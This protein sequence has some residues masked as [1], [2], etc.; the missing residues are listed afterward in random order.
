MT[1]F[2]GFASAHGTY[3]KEETKRGTAKREIK[4]SAKTLREAVTLDLWQRHLSGE[5]P[6]GIITIRE[7]ST[8][9][10]GAIDI[11]QYDMDLGGLVTQ[12]RKTCKNAVLCR[13]KS[14][15]AHVFLFM[16]EPVPAGDMMAKLRS[17]SSVI[18]HGGSEV[19]PKQDT[20]LIDRGDLGNWLNM[21]YFGGDETERYAIKEDGR[22]LSMSQFLDLAE[23]MRMTPE[24]LESTTFHATVAELKDG[25]PC[26][27]QLGAVKVGEGARNNGLFAY[28]VLAKKMSPDGW[29]KVL[30]EW[31]QKYISP[32]L[33]VGE[34]TAVVRSLRK[35]DYQYKCKDQPIQSYCNMALCRHRKYG[36]G[37][38]GVANIVES[39]TILDTEPPLFFVN[40]KTGGTVECDSATLL[41]PRLFQHEVLAQLKQVCFLYKLDDWLPD[42]QDAVSNA[43]RLEAPREVGT[44]GQFEEI[45]E[46]FC[47]DRHAGQ[48]RE[49]ILLGKPWRDEAS[50]LV[51]FRLRDLQD[52]MDRAKFRQL[53]RPQVSSRIRAMGGE[54]EFFNIKGKGINV[55]S[56]PA[57][58]FS[59][60]IAPVDTPEVPE[61][62]L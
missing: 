24:E 39:I 60:Q 57:S 12:I 56:I 27:E 13:T 46:R 26:L 6:L 25:P 16:S 32:P 7:D 23:S 52:A 17:L 43:T 49:D 30:D 4:G 29:E 21:P 62:P 55:W 44:T 33:T 50:G 48:Q 54:S 36:I 61:T 19:F 31:N 51:F 45:L 28:G 11:D 47:T 15:G 35:R 1:L 40:L 42:I 34:V 20:V 18:G 3:V 5:R 8:C 10:W 2:S 41:N 59:W 9:M 37:A 22:G 53:T 58:K 38:A 14:G